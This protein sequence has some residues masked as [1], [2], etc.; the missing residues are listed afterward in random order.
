MLLWPLGAAAEIAAFVF[1]F[2]QS[3]HV[4]AVDVINRSVGGSFIACGLITWQRRPDNRTGKLLTLTGFLFLA[5]PLLIE[6]DSSVLFTLGQITAN[7]WTI[8]FAT[9]ILA[10]PSG[11]I[12][13]R[14]DAAVVVLFV[15][16][17]AV[18]QIV[19]VMFL[20]FPPGKTNV[21]QVSA[22]FATADVI[23]TYQR[24]AIV[25]V[26]GV[27]VVIGV[28]RWVRAPALLRR[29]LLPMLAGSMAA[30][31]LIAWV[32]YRLLADQPAR[33]T[34][35]IT[36]VVLLLVPL[37]FVL[38]LLRTQFARAG[39][40]D[41]V[42]ALQRGSQSGQLADVLAG[43]LHDPSLVLA[44][45]LPGFECYVD[46]EGR[47][48][49]LPA[50]DSGRAATFINH[51]D[52]HVA[53]L[54]H[55]SALVHDPDLLALVC[56]AA[57]I[58][59]EQERLQ[60]QLKARAEEL[61]GSRARIV[62]AGDTAR[63]RLERDLHDGAQQRLVALALALRLAETRIPTD[64]QAAGEL[65]AAAREELAESLAELRELARGIHPAVLDNGLAGALE[66]LASRS[67]VPLSLAVEIDGRLPGPVET[68][69]YFV[70]SEAL[71]NVG[72]Y[73]QASQVSIRVARHNGTAVIEVSDD[74][75]GGAD[76]ARGSGLRGLADRVEALGGRIVVVS[77]AGGGTTL[78][79][80]MPCDATPA[81]A[82]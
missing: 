75:V 46:A 6:L 11:R 38:G 33:A 72:K 5:E 48:V 2:R 66:G 80:E 58:A 34:Q 21:I 26:G 35:T 79:A 42:V 71:A 81:V 53:V 40:A 32:A 30:L 9:L 7:W 49:P 69:A 4:T 43:A 70:A 18:W 47:P 54:V 24:W 64:P 39:M 67:P 16:I 22:D 8:P 65:V 14:L 23:D 63:R 36:A 62:E 68:A 20:P 44:Y 17:E 57:D 10:F 52:E 1:L 76:D 59:L 82:T 56:A 19:Y 55:D 60:T 37:A 61:Q 31:V 74:G 12:S 3:G 29:L 77:P 27:L 73:A 51:D 28:A 13:S 45:W 25:V 15:L 41:L 50:A 78:S